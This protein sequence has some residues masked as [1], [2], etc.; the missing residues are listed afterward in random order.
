MGTAVLG[1]GL[2]LASWVMITNPYIWS[3]VAVQGGQ[4]VCSGG[5]YRLVRHP[6]YAGLI[7]QALSVPFLLGSLWALVP[8]VMAAV[9]II[10][11]TSW[12]DRIL[13]AELP[14]YRDYAQKVRFRV[15]PGI[16]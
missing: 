4:T 16:W 3:K 1:F 12:E 8:G 9:C 10:V 2:G 5:P 13:Q 6:A 7:F 11:A 15:V 14:G